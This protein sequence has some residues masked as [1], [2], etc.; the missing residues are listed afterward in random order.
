MVAA[1]QTTRNER[2][3]EV[4]VIEKT[5]RRSTRLSAGRTSSSPRPGGANDLFQAGDLSVE[6][7]HAVSVMAPN[8]MSAKIA[9]PKPSARRRKR[10][11]EV[12][13]IAAGS[14]S[15]M[16]ESPNPRAKKNARKSVLVV[17]IPTSVSR[18]AG[19]PMRG[20][21]RTSQGGNEAPVTPKRVTVAKRPAPA[22]DRPVG[23]SSRTAQSSSQGSIAGKPRKSLGS[24]LDWMA[25]NADN[26]ESST[27][28][29]KKGRKS[30]A[31]RSVVKDLHAH[32]D[33]PPRPSS[34]GEDVL[35]L[36]GVEET[37][38]N[39]SQR[40]RSRIIASNT[41]QP[42]KGNSK[43]KGKGS[44]KPA[45]T[46]V[47]PAVST[48][49]GYQDEALVESTPYASPTRGESQPLPAP[50]SGPRVHDSYRRSYSPDFP[51]PQ[52]D[53]SPDSKWRSLEFSGFGEEACDSSPPP[54]SSPAQSRIWEIAPIMHE[55]TQATTSTPLR[56]PLSKKRKSTPHRRPIL[57]STPAR[58]EDAR[59][60]RDVEL[61]EDTDGWSDAG[62]A[63]SYEDDQAF[64][65]VCAAGDRGSSPDYQDAEDLTIQEGNETQ[66]A[67]SNEPEIPH[68]NL[69]TDQ[70]ERSESP[71]D[72]RDVEG[73]AHVQQN[74]LP[75]ETG[76]HI[77][78]GEEPAGPVT[79]RTDP[80][81]TVRTVEIKLEEDDTQVPG[82]TQDHQVAREDYQAGS[83]AKTMA[84]TEA[85]PQDQPQQD[86][87]EEPIETAV[88][89][90]S[91]ADEDAAMPAG[92]IAAVVSAASESQDQIDGNPVLGSKEVREICV[93][94][95]KH[96]T[97]GDAPVIS[98]S[99]VPPS[100]RSIPI[101]TEE[102]VRQAVVKPKP[103]QNEILEATAVAL[104]RQDEAVLRHTIDADD[105]Y[106]KLP[107]VISSQDPRAAALAAAILRQVCRSR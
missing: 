76:P 72:E 4:V 20:V 2:R 62:P 32:M 88:T 51:Q 63:D 17:E 42:R 57:S 91:I 70:A 82:A 25:A 21:V 74:E 79:S 99:A 31:P 9:S 93:D 14:T 66:R 39:A 84:T 49:P 69:E 41:P 22:T 53:Y 94:G 19:S 107:I 1:S 77:G 10:S 36:V 33:H 54:R 105:D 68:D 18:L 104:G 95:H 81:I 100:E 97:L 6:S 47:Q 101:S 90:A 28:K 96:H 59:S 78:E 8:R 65:E 5:L 12:N 86:N 92:S 87:I 73:S 23:K 37:L 98:S 26:S 16:Y 38:E 60:E 40:A 46:Q 45:D 7:S 27:I 55:F 11:S 34:P 52:Q 56:T 102:P 44:I 80:Y 43:Y 89:E 50:S 103:L 67:P 13:T 106:T 83:P 85:V 64:V 24:Q 15:V 35:L 29:R 3:S 30:L 58:S 75:S 48:S 61:G 71:S